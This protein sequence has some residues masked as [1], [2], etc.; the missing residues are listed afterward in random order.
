[1]PFIVST[2]WDLPDSY[3]IS[4][5]L[6]L[7]PLGRMWMPTYPLKTAAAG[8]EQRARFGPQAD[9][10]LRRRAKGSEVTQA[11]GRPHFQHYLDGD[12]D[13]GEG[14]E[15]DLDLAAIPGPT[16]VVVVVRLQLPSHVPLP[17]SQMSPSLPLQSWQL[18]VFE[19]LQFQVPASPAPPPPLLIIA[20]V[21]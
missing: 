6:I 14:P 8:A 5:S 17:F 19:Q 4:A 12:G 10:W 1:M 15:L 21:P 7:P 16:P 18:P 11:D 20:L 9:I 13:C 3:A 2:V